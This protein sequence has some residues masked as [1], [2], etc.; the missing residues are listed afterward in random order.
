MIKPFFYVLVEC[1]I[2][3]GHELPLHRDPY[4]KIKENYI[5]KGSK[6]CKATYPK[7]TEPNVPS[8]NI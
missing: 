2:T 3:K 8:T 4:N 6:K 7:K 5:N 1:P